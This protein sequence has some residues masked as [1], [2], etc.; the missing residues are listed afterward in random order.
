MQTAEHKIGENF[1]KR[2]SIPPHAFFQRIHAQRKVL[3]D[4]ILGTM[5]LF[6]D[7]S[8]NNSLYSIDPLCLSL[9][10]FLQF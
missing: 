8:R 3:H 6:Y 4:T 9:I 2:N 5:K 10:S 7:F 1:E